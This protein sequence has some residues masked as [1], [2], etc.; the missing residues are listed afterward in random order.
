MAGWLGKARQ[1]YREYIPL[2]ARKVI[3]AAV[4]TSPAGAPTAATGGF[5]FGY[6]E[7]QGRA[8]ATSI[9]EVTLTNGNRGIRMSD[10]SVQDTGEK[11]PLNVG[12]YMPSSP[13]DTGYG[14]GGVAAAEGE[15]YQPQIAYLPNGQS[16]DLNNPDDLAR[17]FSDRS[18][19]LDTQY[20][21]YQTTE[22]DA[23]RQA[24]E[25][26]GINYGQQEAGINQDITNLGTNR[27][28][29]LTGY[30]QQMADLGE[31]YRAGGAKRQ[32][33]FSGLG[34]RAYQSAQ[35]SS[36]QYANQKYGEAQTA[37]EA[38]K[39]RQLEMFR[40][41]EAGLQQELGNTGRNYNKYLEE[42]RKSLADRLAQAR[43]QMNVDKSQLGT[44]LASIN[45]AKGTNAL[46]FGF[47]P[48]KYTAPTASQI[49]LGQYTKYT[50]FDQLAQSP[51][52]G[53]LKDYKNQTTQAATDPLA[54]Y[55]GYNPTEQQR[56]YLKLYLMGQ[57]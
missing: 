30:G 11:A 37:S 20:N 39:T 16:Y 32:N 33:Y 25:E 4:A 1:K 5:N 55:L 28:T 29:Y 2:K 24:L 41:G 21:K 6:Q 48:N 53:Y 50:N 15:V 17:Y 45:A 43:E 34:S 42:S 51:Q 19:L 8:T 38:D 27:N 26:A 31:G 52:A 22:E 54:Q 56:N 9:G 13:P 36:Q 7:P 46:Q 12:D 23:L 47:D 10:G 57:S 35:G 40:Q 49:D 14:G 3:R 18:G 44:D